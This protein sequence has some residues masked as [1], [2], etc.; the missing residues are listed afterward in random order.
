MIK[1]NTRTVRNWLRWWFKI[2]L[3]IEK[4]VPLSAHF[5]RLA[6][7]ARGWAGIEDKNR[8]TIHLRALK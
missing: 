8:K 2:G 5:S 7:H 6:S 3:R 1:R 4:I